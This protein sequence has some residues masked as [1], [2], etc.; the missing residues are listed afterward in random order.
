MA[1]ENTKEKFLEVM[2]SR[3][4]EAQT[5]ENENRANALDDLKF[6]HNFRHHQWPE[7]D[8]QTRANEKRPML[9]HNLL[10]KFM[11]SMVGAMKQTRPGIK[12]RPKDSAGDVITA[13][14][15]TDLIRQIEKDVESPADQAYDKAYEGAVGNAFGFF[16]LASRYEKDESFEQKLQLQ[17]IANPFN[18]L[19]DPNTANFLKTDAD[20]CFVSTTMSR[21]KFKKKWPHAT[22][23]DHWRSMGTAYEKWFMS[24]TVRIAEYFYKVPMVKV[25]AQLDDLSI[26]EL[27]PKITP[28]LIAQSGRQIIKHKRVFS[29]T[30]MWTKVS[31]NEILEKPRR[32]PGRY[33]PIIPVYGDE[34]NIDGQRALFSFFRDAKDPQTMYNFWLTAATEIVALSPK[35]PYIGTA[36]QF[37]NHE[38]KWRE[39]NLKNYAFLPYN[40]D[41]KTKMAPRRE[42]GSVIPGGHIAMMNIAESNIMGTLGRYE[43]SMGQ[44][45]NERSGKAIKARQSA[46]DQVTFSYLD[47]FHQSLM[48]A[49]YQLVDLIPSIYD[50]NR[51]VRLRGPE[52]TVKFAEINTPYYDPETDSVMIFNDLSRGDYDAEL[53]VSP[54][55]A[56]RRQEAVENMIEI[57]QY[58]PGA[59]PLVADLIIKNMDFPGAQDIA[60]RLKAASQQ[61]PQP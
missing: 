44:T 50:T 56:S 40:A 36:K 55:Y 21:E 37:K 39:A 57:I 32:W 53:D 13:D 22:P 59:G 20:Y 17:R 14:I 8:K 46:S 25:I 30:Y 5:A 43:A 2:R 27:T 61:A 34:V 9:T 16:R 38:K 41:P 29:H 18:V 26:V 45:S 12:V 52:D 35:T 58:V 54:S 42:P 28:E 49:G 24:D 31:G 15:M 6:I 23:G 60:E 19:F 10:R 7:S 48:Y 11:R 4:Q 1:E 47:N 51:I 33:I 3:F